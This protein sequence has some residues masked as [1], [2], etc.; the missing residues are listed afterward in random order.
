VVVMPP[1][2]VTTYYLETH[3]PRELRAK[4]SP[5]ADLALVRIDPPLPEFN[6]FFYTAVG[7]D[8]YW[9]DRLPWSHRQWLDYVSRP[10]LETW[11]LTVQ[12]VPAGYFEL[13]AQPGSDVEIAYFG[14]LPRHVGAG[15]GGHLLTAAIERGW[16]MGARRVWVHTCTLDHPQALANY[17]ARGMQLYKEE[18]KVEEVA[19]RP[20]GPW[21]G[22]FPT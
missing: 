15:L 21:P 18:T 1:I 8:W 3:H 17:Q 2:P 20:V 13:E 16:A 4:R 10:E 6:R 9:N 14:L 11:M 19:A 22:A 7:G 12:G 5:R